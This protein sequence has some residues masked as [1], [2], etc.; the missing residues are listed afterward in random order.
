MGA[1]VVIKLTAISVHRAH[2]YV[3]GCSIWGLL[4]MGGGLKL[5][6]NQKVIG[7]G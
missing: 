2:F 1:R 6:S 7:S 3:H 4:G 5:I